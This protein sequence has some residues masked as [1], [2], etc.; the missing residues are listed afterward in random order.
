MQH[1]STPLSLITLIGGLLLATSG[2]AQFTLGADI[3]NSNGRYISLSEDGMTV[4]HSQTVFENSLRVH[5]ARVYDFDGEDW[6]QRGA[7]ISAAGI[8]TAVWPAIPISLSDDGQRL[9][10]GSYSED[11]PNVQLLKVV[12]W[13]GTQWAQV[14]GIIQQEVS[15]FGRMDAVISG[16][17]N[18]VAI[19]TTTSNLNGDESGLV[20]LYEWNG[21]A[22]QQ[23][24][25]DIIGTSGEELGETLD[26][27][28]S[29]DQLIVGAATSEIVRAYGWNGTTWNQ[30]GSD[31]GTFRTI[32]KGVAISG[33]GQRLATSYLNY[34]D[35]S[36]QDPQVELAGRI[37]TFE[38][39][40]SEWILLDDIYGS[41]H[42]GI[43]TSIALDD[44]GDRMIYGVEPIS[45]I[46]YSVVREFDGT[47]WG[48]VD[49]FIRPSDENTI[50]NSFTKAISGD[51]Q[52]IAIQMLF[53]SAIRVFSLEGDPPQQYALS[54][55]NICEAADPAVFSGGVPTGGTYSGPGVTD[56]GNGTDY[57]FDPTGLGAGT[58]PLTYSVDDQVLTDSV[59]VLP[60]PSVSLSLPDSIMLPYS[61]NIVINGSGQPEGGVY[62]S[63]N[64]DFSDEGDGQ[65]FSFSG[66]LTSP[67]NTISYT[68]IGSNGCSG[69][70]SQAINFYQPDTSLIPPFI[71]L[72]AGIVGTQDYPV[73]PGTPEVSNDGTRV[74]VR[75]SN[76][77]ISLDTVYGQ[78]MAWDGIDWLPLGGRLTMPSGLGIIGTTLS[79]DGTRA[80]VGSILEDLN[81]A[82]CGGVQAYE[83]DGSDWVAIGS[84]LY[85]DM[86]SDWV[87]YEQRLSG[88]GQTLA[89]VAVG[90][91]ADNSTG[92]WIRLFRWEGS[93]WEQLGVD[94]PAMFSGFE[95]DS[96]V[97]ISSDGNRIAFQ[98]YDFSSGTSNRQYQVFEWAGSEW[99]RL[100]DAIQLE[101]ELNPNAS[102]SNAVDLSADGQRVAISAPLANDPLFDA[103]TGRV[104]VLEWDGT[105]WIPVGED[106]SG[107][108]EDDFG[109]SVALSETGD[110]L[111]VGAQVDDTHANFGGSATVYDYD[112]TAWRQIAR[113]VYGD[114]LLAFVG[115]FT[116][117]SADGNTLTV[118]DHNKDPGP[119]GEVRVYYLGE[120]GFQLDTTNQILAFCENEAPQ[121]AAGGGWPLG[122]TYSGDG[123]SDDGNGRTFTVDPAAVGTGDSDLNYTLQQEVTT[124]SLTIQEA[125]TVS[126]ALPDTLFLTPDE[127]SVVT[128]TGLPTGGVYTNAD[129]LFV[130]GE[131]GVNLGYLGTGNLPL[132]TVITYTY[133]ADNGCSEQAEQTVV[134]ADQTVGVRDLTALG[135]QVY[136]NPTTGWLHWQGQVPERVWI[137]DTAGR[138]V[139]RSAAPSQ[140]MDVRSLPSGTYWLIASLPDGRWGGALVQK[141]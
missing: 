24:G 22:W 97:S 139:W 141:H 6:V 65:L 75:R 32:N 64:T 1:H 84:T 126:L 127:A 95:E 51:G 21:T 29:G 60:S 83:W 108:N 130:D 30:M 5:T 124:R 119:L 15:G 61:S 79:A 17:G 82:E 121:S 23:M 107:I 41:Y 54:G 66:T 91:E 39:T 47:N 140:Y 20:R 123:V 27:S 104:R 90:K 55:S 52:I 11:Q 36:G 73:L 132:S 125:P 137:T 43:G 10:I 42:D 94:I 80:V 138:T 34:T 37:E 28:N 69:T 135:L 14:G 26:L 4:A 62:T 110:R 81:G 86:A 99:V 7:D 57:T 2:M 33:D 19:G 103:R 101:E 116:H 74:L 120:L 44:D 76:S 16:N 77:S 136:P 89:V 46:D 118:F 78:V 114:D 58:Y 134:L 18:R 105:D 113:S 115:L 70:I 9:A 67:V 71:Q 98:D 35:F 48:C 122:G 56:N 8:G 92:N 109:S 129:S 31:V 111:V 131:D 87:G 25:Q 93:D 85:G 63:S 12:E 102:F 3:P 88:D 50:G 13:D 53:E 100:S 68:L 128:G 106:L 112:G 72:G 117:L 40:G 38:W 59:E 49:C 45:T 96:K 133:E